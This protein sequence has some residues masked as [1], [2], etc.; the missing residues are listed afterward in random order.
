MGNVEVIAARALAQSIP[1]NE[2]FL[3]E[4]E[5]HITD[6]LQKSQNTLW[7]LLASNTG[8]QIVDTNYRAI[9]HAAM[10]GQ[11]EA[12]N[13]AGIVEM[14]G[15]EFVNL[16]FEQAIKFFQSKKIVSREEFDRMAQAYKR[17]AFNM[18]GLTRQ[19]ELTRVHELLN[20]AMTEGTTRKEFVKQMREEFEGLGVTKQ[21]KA[22][23]ET[24]YS[25][26][27]LGS[28]A[29]GRYQQQ[30]ALAD[31]RPIWQYRTVGD[32]AVREAHRLMDE[33]VA[34]AEDPIWD[35]W[36]PP[37]GHRCRCR[38]ETFT[39]SAA[40]R[41]GLVPKKELPKF[42]NGKTVAPD[43]GWNGSPRQIDIGNEIAARVREQASAMQMLAP[44]TLATEGKGVYSSIG[45]L[46]RVNDAMRIAKVDAF[47]NLTPPKVA[48]LV[49]EQPF[50][51]VYPRALQAAPKGKA[52][53]EVP[54]HSQNS[55]SLEQLAKRLALDPALAS[56]ARSIR[57]LGRASYG[58]FDARIW[59]ANEIAHQALGN[60]MVLGRST[61]ATLQL[62][63]EPGQIQKI[64]AVLEQAELEHGAPIRHAWSVGE[65][66]IRGAG[67]AQRGM[68]DAY[69]NKR[70]LP[71]GEQIVMSK[72][73]L[74]GWKN[75]KIQVNERLFAFLR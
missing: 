29:E 68:V 48:K 33:H 4:I 40:E 64:M 7:E 69:L 34:E 21:S 67:A 26:G 28:F 75:E 15:A 32:K 36:Y 30:N 20:G 43:K 3:D 54:V 41:K 19:Y 5:K 59:N 14:G 42:E 58:K 2:Q 1:Q 55:D 50:F 10:T 53:I 56:I 9:M 62:T 57:V 23:L 16:P 60:E 27:V 39:R 61:E 47:A 37:N 73:P 72:K 13:V 71:K 11:L 49:D 12:A 25:N 6:D 63:A 52:F 38:V 8:A 46:G 31:I 24:V 66:R 17:Q 35:E 70:P 65:V 45:D 74:A 44:P 22:H 51:S 18:A